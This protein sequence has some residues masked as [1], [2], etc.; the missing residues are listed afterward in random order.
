VIERI[1]Q[2]LS[3]ER[4]QLAAEVLM[5][6]FSGDIGY[7]AGRAVGRVQSLARALQIVEEVLAGERAREKKL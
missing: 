4:N 3:E 7:E 2:R 6:G 5:K 1:I